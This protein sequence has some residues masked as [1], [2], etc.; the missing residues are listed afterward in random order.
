MKNILLG[1]KFVS[2]E[3]VLV[4]LPPSLLAMSDVMVQEL[5]RH[6]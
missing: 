6:T 1:K 5:G 4:T 3:S 2:G